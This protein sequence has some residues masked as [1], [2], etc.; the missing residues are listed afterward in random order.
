MVKTETKYITECKMDNTEWNGI[1]WN[2]MGWDRMIEC[3]KI[4]ME[5]IEERESKAGRESRSGE[6]K[7]EGEEKEYDNE[8]SNKEKK[9]KVQYTNA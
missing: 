2:R 4:D 6:K 5:G 7:S 8:G 3:G 1:E 9:R